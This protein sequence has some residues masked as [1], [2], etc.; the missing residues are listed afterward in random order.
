MSSMGP[1]A[2]GKR[3]RSP[4]EQKI[5]TASQTINAIDGL[6]GRQGMVEG[7]NTRV[8]SIALI[9]PVEEDRIVENSDRR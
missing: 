9:L 4:E 1:T 6:G 5:S 8:K 7:M 3:G 2:G